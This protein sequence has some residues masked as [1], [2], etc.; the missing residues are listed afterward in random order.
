VLG[1][2]LNVVPD[3]LHILPDLASDLRS[4]RFSFIQNLERI[5]PNWMIEDEYDQ[6]INGLGFQIGAFHDKSFSSPLRHP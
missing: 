5:D 6:L 2:D 1:E 3:L 4:T